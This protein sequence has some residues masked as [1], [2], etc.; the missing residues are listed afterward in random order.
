MKKDLWRKI[1]SYDYRYI[2]GFI[3]LG[4]L[5]IVL[6]A[7]R[8]WDLPNGLTDSEIAAATVSGQFSWSGLVTNFGEHAGWLINL[9]WTVLQNLSINLFGFSTFAFRLPA[10]IL[11]ILSIAGLMIIFCKWL[12][13]NAAIVGG[14]LIVPSA[15]FIG[16]SR[17][18]D[19]SAMM[20]FLTVAMLFASTIAINGKH[21][22][23]RLVAK[24]MTCVVIALLLYCPGG[25]Y[26]IAILLIVGLLHPKTRLIFLKV[27]IWRLVVVG[28]VGLIV[29]SPLAISLFVG[30]HEFIGGLFLDRNWL[31]DN[32][33]LFGSALTGV[34]TGFAGGFVT[35]IISV[36]GL[37]VALVGLIRICAHF[38]SA[39]SYLMLALLV[40][41]LM[42]SLFQPQFLYLLFVPLAILI[43]VGADVLSDEWYKL[44]PSNP[45]ARALASVLIAVLIL[46]N[47]WTATMRYIEANHYDEAV[48]YN[49]N[50]EFEAVRE[51][52]GAGLTW[53]TKR[54]DPETLIVAP[55]QVEF[56]EIL[57]SEFP[58][59]DVK[60]KFSDSDKPT[61]IVLES[62]DSE[63]D[64]VIPIEIITNSR[65]KDSVL[66]RVYSK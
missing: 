29:V 1:T 45:Y 6:A 4:I 44:F 27:E 25:V 64:S 10:V 28:A 52:I 9:P 36:I 35:P 23:A 65:A 31:I 24:I 19:G 66:L 40:P 50:Q 12:K 2:V 5:T 39:R 63:I 51:K 22:W 15:L 46:V 58:D 43:A 57:V 37:I 30:G 59:M 14:F 18:G 11:M 54:H 26:I 42:W 61:T 8:F 13:K 53:M 16:L 3:V 56:Y 47:G 62:A 7:Y 49:Y 60:A 48:V 17:N 55:Y 41:A 20:I 32:M 33:P 21:E 38:Y 34:G